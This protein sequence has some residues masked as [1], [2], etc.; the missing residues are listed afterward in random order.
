[1][2]NRILAAA[3][4]GSIMIAAPA[5]AGGNEGHSAK[6]TYSDLN[7]NTEAGQA[8]LEKRVSAAVRS[9]CGQDIVR[10]GTRLKSSSQRKCLAEADKS[11]K[12]QVAAIIED[13]RRGG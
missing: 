13:A 9:V 5:V 6:I 8:A 10:T 7:L 11:A 12:Q 3:A 2:F 4:V 1:M